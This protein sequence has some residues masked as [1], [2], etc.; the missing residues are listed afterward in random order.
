MTHQSK[1]CFTVQIQKALD[2]RLAIGESKKEAK[3]QTSEN[4]RR[5]SDDKIFSWNTY[6]AYMQHA[7]YF[8]KWI[9]KNHP[10]CR[11]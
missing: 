6:R 10:N 4:G 7:N 8:G 2:A 5:L 3:K 1:E 9:E 11:T